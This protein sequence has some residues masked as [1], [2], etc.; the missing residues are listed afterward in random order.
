[1]GSENVKKISLLSTTKED[2]QPLSDHNST[3]SVNTEGALTVDIDSDK[4]KMNMNVE[5]PDQTKIDSDVIYISDHEYDSD[6]EYRRKTKRPGP[7]SKTRYK[8]SED[9][10]NKVTA[11]YGVKKSKLDKKFVDNKR[12]NT[13]DLVSRIKIETIKDFSKRFS[14]FN[15][16]NFSVG[17]PN[18]KG[19]YDDNEKDTLTQML[20]KNNAKMNLENTL[21]AENENV[22]KEESSSTPLG[23]DIEPKANSEDTVGKESRL[24]IALLERMGVVRDRSSTSLDAQFYLTESIRLIEEDTK[25]K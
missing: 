17:N 22:N 9:E 7:K 25:K 11:R 6:Y 5:F 15:K 10:K 8:L 4:E 18:Q 21:V 16:G 20:I 23:A 1:M 12:E 24:A 2:E 3:I 19:K 14:E 13:D